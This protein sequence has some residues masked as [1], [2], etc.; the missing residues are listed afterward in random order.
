MPAV[1]HPA[2]V[3]RLPSPGVR[4]LPPPL[5][6]RAPALVRVLRPTGAAVRALPLVRRLAGRLGAGALGGLARRGGARRGARPQVWRSAAHRRRPRLRDGVP[7]PAGTRGCLA[8]NGAPR[9]RAGARARG[10][11]ERALCAR[12]EP[13]L[14]T[15]A[16]GGGRPAP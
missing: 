8:G 1:P 11:T 5:A 10:Q 7:R 4:R 14:G 16:G 3:P 6:S 12:P 9:A 15:A 2:L 13:A